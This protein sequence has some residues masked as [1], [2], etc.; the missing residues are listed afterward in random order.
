MSCLKPEILLFFLVELGLTAAELKEVVFASSE[1]P[2]NESW[3]WISAA[4]HAPAWPQAVQTAKNTDAAGVWNSHQQRGRKKRKT[5]APKAFLTAS[6]LQ[7][8][9]RKWANTQRS[10]KADSNTWVTRSRV[11]LEEPW[12]LLHS[13]I[14]S[15]C[16][17]LWCSASLCIG[18]CGFAGVWAYSIK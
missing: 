16:E 6:L 18:G 8:K 12:R 1:I 17:K 4:V 5:K 13:N 11:C 2:V 3:Y 14:A 7:G 10:R 15:G 9:V